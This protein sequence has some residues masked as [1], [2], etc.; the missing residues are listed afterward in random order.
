MFCF[1]CLARKI[2]DLNIGTTP[3]MSIPSSSS[4]LAAF[5]ELDRTRRS[6]IAITDASGRLLTSTSGK[7]LKLWLKNPGSS[8]LKDSILHFLQKIRANEIDVCPPP[9]VLTVI[10]CVYVCCVVDVNVCL[11]LMLMCVAWLF[12]C[13]V[14]SWSW[15]CNGVLVLPL[16]CSC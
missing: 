3:V 15:L 6:G 11:L 8:L 4:A 10:A 14:F 2:V 16:A 7:D 13:F 1:F 9:V 12:F 5:K